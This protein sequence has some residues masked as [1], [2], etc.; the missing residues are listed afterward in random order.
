MS[1]L[2]EGSAYRE[3]LPTDS[4]PDSEERRNLRSVRVVVSKSVASSVVVIM[5]I[6][7]SELEFVDQLIDKHTLPPRRGAVKAGRG[8]TDVTYL[9]PPLLDSVDGVI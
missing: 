6:I 8:Q 7:P 9:T 4:M 5:M 2:P 1:R 3:P